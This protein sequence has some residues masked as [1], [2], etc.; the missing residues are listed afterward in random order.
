MENSTNQVFTPKIWPFGTG[1][2]TH[3]LAHVATRLMRNPLDASIWVAVVII[4][5]VEKLRPFDRPV[6]EVEK[7]ISKRYNHGNPDR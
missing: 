2:A 5:K 6:C 1:T 4:L 3:A 7:P